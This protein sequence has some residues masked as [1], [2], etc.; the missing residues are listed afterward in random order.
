MVA[1]RAEM[2]DQSMVFEMAAYWACEMV[3]KTVDWLVEEMA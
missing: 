3:V 1:Q 2:K